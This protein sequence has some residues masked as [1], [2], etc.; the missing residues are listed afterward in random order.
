MEDFELKEDTSGF[1]T[2]DEDRGWRFG[3]K[4]FFPDGFI[5]DW[6]LKDTY[7]YPVRG[8]TWFDETPN[9]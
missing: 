5:L 6:E 8:W 3:R 9:K 2:F 1:Y 4:I 7:E